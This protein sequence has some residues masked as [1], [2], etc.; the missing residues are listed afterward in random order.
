MSCLLIDNYDSFT[1]NLVHYV[2][3]LGIA[4]RVVRNDEMSPQQALSLKPEWLL[5]SPG[6]GTPHESGISLDLIRLAATER[7]PL[8][9]V[10]LGHE[11]IGE[12]FG[13]KVVHAGAVMHGKVSPVFHDQTGPFAG[14]PTPLVA[15]RYHSLVLEPKTMPA[16]L[17]ITAW[18]EKNN[19]PAEIMGIAHRELPIF[20]VQFHPEAILTEHGHD[21]LNNFFRGSAA[22]PGAHN[23][24]FAAQVRKEA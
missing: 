24:G 15:A 12:V 22:I 2:R 10:C 18:T 13:A 21:M 7:I 16:C 17:R 20:G 19:Q 8:L 14:L 9:G 11:A 1:Y 6:P 5:I 4:V 3:E 23:R